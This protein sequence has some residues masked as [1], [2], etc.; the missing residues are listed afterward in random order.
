MYQIEYRMAKKLYNRQWGQCAMCGDRLKSA[1]RRF[2][3]KLNHKNDKPENS[4]MLCKDCA[5]KV[6]KTSRY[7]HIPAPVAWKTFPYYKG[8]AS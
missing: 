6:Q 3:H 7:T 1:D 8:P 4:V 2:A 5:R